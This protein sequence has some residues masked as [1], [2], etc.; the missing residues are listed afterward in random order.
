MRYNIHGVARNSYG[1]ALINRT[2]NIYINGSAISA[3]VYD[4]RT[5]TTGLSS[6]QTDTRRK[7]F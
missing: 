7:N 2:V 3:T 5:S 6:V 1:R 4:T